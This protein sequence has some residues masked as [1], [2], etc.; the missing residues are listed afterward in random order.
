MKSPITGNEMIAVSEYRTV[1]IEG[2]DFEVLMC[3][4]RCEESGEQFTSTH[5]DEI[6]MKQIDELRKTTNN[7]NK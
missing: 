4:Y 1:N 2:K 5:L 3:F 7:G 6:N